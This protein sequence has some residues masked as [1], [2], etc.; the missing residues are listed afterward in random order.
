MD[1]E[2]TRR[3]VAAYRSYAVGCPGNPSKAFADVLGSALNVPQPVDPKVRRD[4]VPR[5]YTP[6]GPRRHD[7]RA[8]LRR[9]V[10]A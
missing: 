4:A 6:N 8:G 10:G 7:N 1:G 2:E 3:N 9:Q 5:P